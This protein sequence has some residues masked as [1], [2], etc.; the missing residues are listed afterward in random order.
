M[1]ARFARNRDPTRLRRVLVLPVAATRRHK[2][3]VVLVKAAQQLAHFHSPTLRP[4]RLYL[5]SPMQ[6]KQAVL[7]NRTLALRGVARALRTRGPDPAGRG[8]RLERLVGPLV[9]HVET[10]FQMSNPVNRSF[11]N[12]P[13]IPMPT[14]KNPGSVA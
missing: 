13:S 10:D 5:Y 2:K 8:L 4:A 11:T 12:V 6:R 9:I 14:S 1:V 7:F 3:P